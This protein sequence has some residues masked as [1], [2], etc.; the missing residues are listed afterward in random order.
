MAV[1][2]KRFRSV[3]DLKE[4]SIYGQREHSRNFAIDK[5]TRVTEEFDMVETGQ[6]LVQQRR[7]QQSSGPLRTYVGSDNLKNLAFG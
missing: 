2:S 5:N 1:F 3:G 6:C 7:I 4:S